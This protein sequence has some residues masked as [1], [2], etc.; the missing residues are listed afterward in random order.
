MG[1]CEWQAWVDLRRRCERSSFPLQCSA[2]HLSHSLALSKKEHPLAAR[3]YGAAAPGNPPRDDA[4]HACA[5]VSCAR[6]RVHGRKTWTDT[7][8]LAPSAEVRLV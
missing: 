7:E 1:V 3:W 6:G 5:R 4:Q 2:R 8:V